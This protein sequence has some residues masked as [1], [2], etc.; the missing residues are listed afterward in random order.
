VRAGA[1]AGLPTWGLRSSS[2]ERLRERFW[3]ALRDDLDAPRAL[4]V[5]WEIAEQ[6][7]PLPLRAQLIRE[8]GE[9]IGLELSGPAPLLED[10]ALVERLVAR[11]DAAREARDFSL[12]DALRAELVAKGVVV[13]DSAGGSTWRR[14]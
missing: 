13:E 7:E 1:G 5:L 11:R 9:S 12:S 8:L 6:P 4:S 10:D 3:E 2:L 14:T